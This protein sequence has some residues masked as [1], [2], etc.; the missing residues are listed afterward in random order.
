M[1]SPLFS[2]L[3]L[4]GLALQNRVIVSPMC[5]YSAEDGSA[6]DWHMQ[7]LGSLAISG[8]GLLFTEATAVEAA[9]RITLGCLGLYSD[10]NEAALARVVAACRRFGNTPLGI[11]LAHAGRKASA[12]LPWEGGGA[13]GAAEGAWPTVG[14]SALA[15]D[16][17]WHV[18]TALDEGAMSRIIAA[19]VA[20]VGRAARLGFDAIELHSAHG[21]LLHQFLSPIANRRDDRYGGS[22]ENRMRF[23]LAV[24]AAARAAWPAAKPMGVR[25]SATDWIPGG[26]T[27]DETVVYAR[28]LKGLGCDFIGAS[29]GGAGPHQR[30]P[31]GPGYQVPLAARIRAEAGILTYAVGLI[32]EPHQA[33]AVVARGEAD[34]IAL[35]RAFLDDPRWVWHAAEALGAAAAYPPQYERSRATLWPGARLAR[36]RAEPGSALT[37]AG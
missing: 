7:H 32:A 6:S 27:L 22:L 8:A 37:R 20:A 3:A 13:L 19:F 2:P 12:H 14:A 15:F 28:A 33:E 29:S 16:Q 11:Q 5:Q 9:G 30:V 36:P 34:M 25:V 31:I 17:G 35:A 26:L 1:T 24:F 23:P 10:A 4:R 21:Y 18:P